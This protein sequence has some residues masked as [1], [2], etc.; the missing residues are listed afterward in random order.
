V[1]RLRAKQGA[2]SPSG[3]VLVTLGCFTCVLGLI[4]AVSVRV[5][6]GYSPGIFGIHP[7]RKAAA[8]A[9]STSTDTAP[10][11]AERTF[12]PAP[13]FGPTPS[14]TRL[15]TSHSTTR[16]SP[17]VT[18]TRPAWIV[19]A[20]TPDSASGNAASTTGVPLSNPVPPTTG[21][22]ATPTPTPTPTAV[23]PAPVADDSRINNPSADVLVD[24]VQF[25]T[26]S[27]SHLTVTISGLRPPD[28]SVVPSYTFMDWG[29]GGARSLT[30]PADTAAAVPTAGYTVSHTYS[31]DGT[32]VITWGFAS[33]HDRTW[34]H[35]VTLADPSGIDPG[36]I[37][38]SQDFEGGV[39]HFV[40]DGPEVEWAHWLLDY[41]DGSAV[42]GAGRSSFTD[43]ATAHPYDD[44]PHR[45]VLT[46]IGSDGQLA[47]AAVT[48]P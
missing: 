29:D 46:A 15:P 40:A 19:E 32:Y 22:S 42:S 25:G 35:S 5:I 48:V 43:D 16:V 47:T 44:Q 41:G 28:P 11:L 8:A 26:S 27:Q 17:G 7:A 3:G 20:P 18:S 6:T 4:V 13:S 12:P 38:L 1:I 30:Y 24:S 45:A 9:P 10:P 14:G 23:S 21:P 2:P 34:S 39:A 31:Q 33:D 37:R 36:P